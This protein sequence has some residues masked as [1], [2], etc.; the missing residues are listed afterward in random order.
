[1]HITGQLGAT[2]MLRSKM[3]GKPFIGI[4]I[5]NTAIGV[6]GFDR[7]SGIL[8]GLVMLKTTKDTQFGLGPLVMINTTSRIPAFVV[9]IYR[10]R[11]S[12]ELAVNLYGGT[13]SLDYTPGKNDLFSIGGDVDVKEFPFKPKNEDLPRRCRFVMTSFR[14]MVKYRRRILPN[15]FVEAEGGV[16][17]KMSARVNSRYGTHEYVEASQNPQPFA[18]FGVT[19]QL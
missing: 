1:M 11:F 14:P 15:M 4:G 18:G 6:H 3:L 12:D 13:V 10:H 9:L 16:A 5:A 19:Y 8:M 7:V 17:L 2:A